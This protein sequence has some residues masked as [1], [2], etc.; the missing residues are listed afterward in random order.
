MYIG[1]QAEKAPDRPALIVGDSGEI[2]SYRELDDRS[3]RLA[4]LLQAHGL[5]RG[6]T[7][8]L[9]MENNPRFMEVVWA[10]R[11]SGLYLTAVNR[12]LTADEA[13]YI[14]A[15]S[16]ATVL[17]ASYAMAQV[18]ADLPARLPRCRAF[19]MTDGTIPGWSA[20]ESAVSAYPNERLEQEWLGELM[21]Y[22]SGTTGRPK[23]VR[24]PLRDARPGEDDLLLRV[25]QGYGFGE[26][27]IYLSPAPMYHAAPLVFSLGVQHTGG[28][29]IMMPHFDAA[30]SLELIQRHGVTHSQWVPT[31]FVR[32]LKLPE[33]ERRRFD[34]SSHRCAIHAAAPCPVSV[35][36]AMIEW[37][38]PILEEYYGGTEGNG[39]TRINS[40]EWLAH[41]GSV[42][43]AVIGVL[44]ICDEAGNELDAGER[45]LVYFERD[46]MPFAYYKDPARTAAAQH[47]VHGTWSTLGDVGYVD[48][49]G[50]LYLTD[51]KA[52]MIISGGV[53]IYPREVEDVLIGHPAVRDVAVFGVPDPEM[54]EQVKA[55][56][57]LMEG[58]E[59][60]DALAGALIDYGRAR[61]AHFK[62]PKSVDFCDALPRLPTGKLYKQR[63]RAQYLGGE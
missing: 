24:R 37:W 25:V 47:P 28:T 19:L 2:L 36:R 40:A 39:L 51:R 45:G 34:L 48:T 16:D 57:E 32:M 33:N 14:I 7:V 10:A 6:D 59:P 1:T 31:M 41:P 44:H 63:L 26:D 4:R 54:G 17:I 60:C 18:A 49:D 52:F 12:Y 53:N 20:Y 38:G 61:L 30:G 29:V 46:T 9:F 62:V 35:K 43:R 42:G 58:V 5:R 22:S 50:Y 11:R 15:D 3:N 55:V 13:A 56:V 8:A 27:T 23:G 21:L